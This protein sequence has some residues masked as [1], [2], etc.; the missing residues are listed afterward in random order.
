MRRLIL[1]LVLLALAIVGLSRWQPGIEHLPPTET[2]KPQVTPLPAGFTLIPTFVP[3]YPCQLQNVEV[4]D[5]ALC[6]HERVTETILARGEA[7]TFI[8]HDYSV[9]MGCWG[10]I[11]QDIHEL[12]VCDQTSGATTALTDSLVTPLLPSPDGKW[13]VYGTMSMRSADKDM[14]RP[15]VYRVRSNGSD[16]SRLDTQDFP[17][18]AVGAPGDLRWLDNAWIALTLWDGTQDDGW[19]PYRLKADGSGVYEPLAEPEPAS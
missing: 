11:N 3:A 18:F 2:P 8:R 14:L 4:Y 17:D 1:L 13:L 15:H 9:G 7:V 19:H 5:E 6:R 10:S 16:A 12:R